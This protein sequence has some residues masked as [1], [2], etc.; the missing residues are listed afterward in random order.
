MILYQL[1]G[2]IYLKQTLLDDALQLF[3]KGF[4]DPK[5]LINLFPEFKLD[6]P[7]IIDDR[8]KSVADSLN[9]VY[10]ISIIYILILII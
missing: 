2:M 10:D 9:S 5:L 1:C 4:I 3:Q 7:L 8:I 6:Q